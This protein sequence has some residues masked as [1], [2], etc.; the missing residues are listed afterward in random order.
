MF[1]I[2]AA[3]VAL[4]VVCAHASRVG[5]TSPNT[6]PKGPVKEL[7]EFEPPDLLLL[8]QAAVDAVG[9][10]YLTEAS[11]NVFCLL[12]GS[13]RVLWQYAVTDNSVLAP[14]VVATW[15][16]V[17]VGTTKGVLALSS[18]TGAM[19]WYYK[20]TATSQFPTV[21]V[22]DPDIDTTHSVFLGGRG[23]ANQGYL[24]SLNG[25]TG[26]TYWTTVT[27][28]GTADLQVGGGYVLVGYP[29]IAVNAGKV[30][31]ASYSSSNGNLIATKQL[32]QGAI[33]TMFLFA[34]D[35][36]TTNVF[37]G[38]NTGT[39]VTLQRLSI[40]SNLAIVWTVTGVLSKV[41]GLVGPSHV[42]LAST[43]GLTAYN[44]QTG[45]GE[46]TSLVTLSPLQL[47]PSIVVVGE[48]LYL[49]TGGLS[50]LRLACLGASTGQTI[51]TFTDPQAAGV[52]NA[53]VVDSQGTLFVETFSSTAGSVVYSLNS[54]TGK[55][56]W[57]YVN[58]PD[59]T[60][61]YDTGITVGPGVLYLGNSDE[62]LVIGHS[63][64]SSNAGKVAGAVIGTLLGVGCA[65]AAVWFFKFRRGGSGFKPIGSSNPGTGGSQ[66][67]Y[68]I[69]GGV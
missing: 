45:V 57:K 46:W 28:G 10:V 7:A 39:A 6:G 17:Y 23:N 18:S 36:P 50:T 61:Y 21:V 47:F 35:N 30:V 59:Q 32:S 42:Y 25:Q 20:D 34:V 27:A 41:Y 64:S 4:A 67:A 62:L 31:V 54:Q 22:L 48:Y 60:V 56:N 65:A 51:W 49:D 26:N 63:T 29:G 1:F 2:R 53:P 9:D 40:V 19:L 5:S 14:P 12:A 68:S 66:G 33:V 16:I 15:G 52:F 69:H 3:A 13:S 44:Q 24:T 8:N 38:Y 58:D 55:Q 37:I 43:T 11:V